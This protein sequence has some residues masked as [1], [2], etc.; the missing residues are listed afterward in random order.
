MRPNSSKM[1]VKEIERLKRKIE[2]LEGRLECG[3][4]CGDSLNNTRNDLEDLQEVYR[5]ALA[6]SIEE[7]RYTTI[8]R[9]MAKLVNAGRFEE[10][11]EYV[12][13]VGI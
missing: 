6:H 12:R 4:R 9:Y 8:N 3:V 7:E 11:T 10:L 1:F 5:K 13:K 2:T